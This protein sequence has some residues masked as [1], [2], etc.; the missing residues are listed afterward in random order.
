MGIVERDS[1]LSAEDEEAVK[2]MET[3]TRYDAKERCYYTRLL[4]KLDPGTSLDSNYNVAQFR[5]QRSVKRAILDGRQD[6]IDKAYREQIEAGFA[7]IVP[8]DEK[9]S[10]K[11]YTL[12]SRPL[13]DD[14]SKKIRVVLD[15]SCKCR[16]SGLSLNQALYQGPNE[17]GDLCAIILRMRTSKY[18]FVTDIAR[19][20]WAIRV[21]GDDKDYLRYMWQFKGQ[22]EMTLM[23]S[24]SLIF[25]SISSPFQATWV[26]NQHSIK[27]EEQFP[28]ARKAIR[29]STYVDD[30]SGFN[31]NIDEAVKM[32][33]E[34]VDLLKLAS[35][36]ARKWASNVPAILDKAG[37]PLVDRQQQTIIKMLG[38]QWDTKEDEICFDYAALDMSGDH[39]T[40][41][42]MI[43]KASSVF[44]PCGWLGPILLR[45]KLLLRLT[46]KAEIPWDSPIPDEVNKEW[47]I[48]KKEIPLLNKLRLKRYI[49]LSDGYDVCTFVDASQ[50]AFGCVVYIRTK[51]EV[52]LIFSKTRVAPIKATVF[53][54]EKIS[55]AR[56]ELLASL[57]GVRA[58]NY[59]V[60]ALHIKPDNIFYFTDSLITLY[61]IRNGA[62][63]YKQ[64][65]S[66]RVK[67]I[68]A[69]SRVSEWK[70][71]PGMLNA[72]DV[73]SRA[74]LPSELL[75]NDLFF[76]APHFLRRSQEH[77][78]Q[79]KALSHKEALD[80]NALDLAEVT[81]AETS[82]IAT[83]SIK[84]PSSLLQF[85]QTKSRWTRMTNV[86]A[87]V[88]R[89]LV[90]RTPALKTK[91]RLIARLSE[92]D[93]GSKLSVKERRVSEWIWIKLAQQRAFPKDVPLLR[94]KEKTGL[95][96]NM[97]LWMVYMDDEGVMRSR[98]RLHLS[99]DIAPET[100]CPAILPRY[101][102]IV[103]KYVLHIHQTWLHAGKSTMLN[104]IRRQFRLSGERTEMG[105]IISL[106]PVLGCQRKKLLVQEKA[107]LPTDRSTRSLPWD[108]VGLDF[109][110]PY[111]VTSSCHTC[112]DLVKC[113]G[114]IFTCFVTRAVHLE[115]VEDMST[116]TFLQA[117]TRFC[118]RSATPSVV[119]SDN[120]KTY[121]KARKELIRL[122]S[123]VQWDQVADHAV[124]KNIVW[125][126]GISRM[127]SS[128]GVI[129]RC[130]G[131]IKS[132]LRTTLISRGMTV[133]ELETLLFQ[134][135]QLVNSR[136]LAID[137]HEDSDEFLMITPALLA[138]GRDLP[139]LPLDHRKKEDV[140]DVDAP[141]S[142]MQAHRKRLLFGFW[143]KWVRQ[144]LVGAQLGKYKGK[145]ASLD[146]GQLVF[147]LDTGI[148]M[149]TWRLGRVLA[150]STSHDGRIRTVRLKVQGYKQELI[151]HINQLAILEDKSFSPPKLE[152]EEE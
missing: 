50:L 127:P 104:Y 102:S 2:L 53:E 141:F 99:K 23:R 46:W 21:E 38:I 8:A 90:K 44:D 139:L 91:S 68:N 112:R 15:A 27:F 9:L 147:L 107:P 3:V 12:P 69:K 81:K 45:A 48:W 74:C 132:C 106:C 137:Y 124:K 62:A 55:I 11:C 30:I 67:E 121:I 49:N 144:Y 1:H 24:L 17:M 84:T 70:F 129:E 105:R 41:R 130:V 57:T 36:K 131:Q 83:V 40:K 142:R 58:T 110:G 152:E 100:S 80:Q 64:W 79:E 133:R 52:S 29:D 98:T 43:S 136:P 7:E 87:Y 82:L 37:I 20:F 88:I 92:A 125:N 138:R 109:F 56:M 60:E 140:P 93:F 13:Y 85:E 151:R 28:R 59:V 117:F 54:D 25:G 103:E 32:A 89:F 6:D 61:R 47:I 116:L 63:K 75:E 94:A 77:W 39:D 95:S 72:S 96:D 76:T 101:C 135:E 115:L 149:G 10:Q 73:I 120:S 123:Q 71:C 108:K 114:L 16:I 5:A 143:R 146:V 97:R 14:D 122:F 51:A 119:F 86:L 65:V 126:F 18:V 113:W 22:N 66:A 111:L 35:M 118:S 19:M 150:T 78:P 128:N 42:Q 34:I 134:A 148:K 4:W 33:V 31:P 145:E 26:I